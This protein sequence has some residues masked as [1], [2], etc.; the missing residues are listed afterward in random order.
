MSSTRDFA[1]STRH[2]PLL[3]VEHYFDIYDQHFAKFIK[4][5]C[6]MLE[7]GVYNGGSLEMWKE[8]LGPSSSVS[9]I[10]ISP[11][12][13]NLQFPPGIQV[14]LCNQE[15]RPALKN[16]SDSVGGFDLIL[17]DGGH[18]MSHQIN[19]FEALFPLLKP[20]GVYM[21]EDT[22]TS[23]W[24]SFGGGLRSPGSFMEY[25]KAAT[26][27]VNVDHFREEDT[28]NIPADLKKALKEELTSVTFYDSM[29]VFTKGNKTPKRAFWYNGEA[30]IRESGPLTNYS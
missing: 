24:K 13:L 11:T 7:I 30:G 29:I 23:Y 1:E 27:Y 3:K 6:K 28:L 9:G 26:D 16:L 5:P 12:I 2:K 25:A 8:F 21:V 10:D 19:S 4:T 20:N 17:D 14:F 18:R 22:H 15:D